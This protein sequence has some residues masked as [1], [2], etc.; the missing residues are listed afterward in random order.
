MG[1]GDLRYHLNKGIEFNEE[2]TKFIAACIII[3]I[4]KLHDQNV[5]HR[6]VKPEN[7][8]FDKNGYLRLTD[9]GIARYNQN[10]N[11]KSKENISGTLGYMA[12]EVLMK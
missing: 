3:A 4:S 7:L 12:L 2:Q 8:V 5:I 11:T 6:D 10:L 9:F 1:G